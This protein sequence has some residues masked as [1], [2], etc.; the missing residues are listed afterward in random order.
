MNNLRPC[1]YRTEDGEE[2]RG[3]FHTWQQISVGRTAF[4]RAIVEKE[5]GEVVQIAPSHITFADRFNR[6]ENIVIPYGT[7]IIYHG[8][9]GWRN[10]KCYC[11]HYNEEDDTYNIY[12]GWDL[13]HVSKHEIEVYEWQ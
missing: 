2:F 10:C 9:N 4:M 8:S 3:Y 12:N 7:K 5:N 11:G 6:L 1:I 13:C